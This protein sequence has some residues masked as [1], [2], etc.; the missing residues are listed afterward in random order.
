MQDL[1][2]QDDNKITRTIVILS[3]PNPIKK[4]ARY[5]LNQLEQQLLV[6][7]KYRQIND[8][9]RLLKKIGQIKITKQENSTMLV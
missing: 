7:C 2:N 4:S 1:E 3:C 8:A 9:E 5:N 6:E